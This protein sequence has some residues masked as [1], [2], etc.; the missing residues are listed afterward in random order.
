MIRDPSD[1]TVREKIEYAGISGELK[2]P[3]GPVIDTSTS[4]LPITKAKADYLKRLELSRAW[5]KDYFKP[6]DSLQ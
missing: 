2:K 5:L 3:S 4:G 1:G 6:K